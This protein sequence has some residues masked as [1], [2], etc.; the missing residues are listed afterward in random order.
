VNIGFTAHGARRVTMSVTDSQAERYGADA[1]QSDLRS[2]CNDATYSIIAGDCAQH[3][4][5][6]HVAPTL[7]GASGNVFV[8]PLQAQRRCDYGS[9]LP[10]A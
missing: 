6:D 5:S 8:Y 2:C 4:C 3:L 10:A 7:Y 1:P 9:A